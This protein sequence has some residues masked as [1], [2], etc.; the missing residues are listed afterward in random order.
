M[1]LLL[2]AS[3]ALGLAFGLLLGWFLARGT[4]RRELAEAQAAHQGALNAQQT[5]FAETARRLGDTQ[6]DLQLVRTQLDE[7]RQDAGAVREENARLTAEIAHQRAVVPEKVALLDKARDQLRDTF[8]ALAAEVLRGANTEF[9][10]LAQERL[11]TVQREATADLGRRQQ[12]IDE[13]VKPIREALSSVDRKLGEVE[14]DRL[15]SNAELATVLKALG[16]SQAQLRTE[17]QQLVRALRAPAI[18]GRWGEIQLRRVVELAGLLE[19]VDFDE[20]PSAT[21]ESGRLRPDMAVK[22]PGGRQ[23]VVD[24]KVPLEAYLNAIDAQEDAARAT[25]LA[26]H[27]RQ[28][29]DHVTRLAAKAYWEQFTPSPEFVLMFIGSEGIYHAALQA[30][31]ELVE[32]AARQKVLIAGPMSLIGILYAIAQGWRHENI[33]ANAEE[34][35]KLGRELHD[36]V[37]KMTEHLDTLR[38]RLDGTVRAFNDTVGSYENRVLVSARRFKDLGATTGGDIGSVNTVDTVPR[39][40]QSANLLGL[41][42]SAI[43]EGE[44]LDQPDTEDD[45]SGHS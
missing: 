4:G 21:T 23:V 39:V 13:L 22:L 11:G 41:P 27:A 38:Q 35:S 37:G 44:T 10:K 36:R 18:R 14:R 29:R 26:D 42:D 30:D 6:E 15:Q 12:A 20:Q 3:A 28:V 5:L 25:F 1:D 2:A 31:P 40:L 17:T 32:Y 24:A 34:I 43:V 9:V 8:N 7:A 45:P 19:S 33:A 16:Q